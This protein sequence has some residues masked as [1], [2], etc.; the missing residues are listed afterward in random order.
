M[1]RQARLSI[2]IALATILV[3]GAPAARASDLWPGAF[4]S[5][6]QI[7]SEILAVEAAHPEIVDVFSIG[8]SYEGR[9]LYAAKIS[10]NV[11]LEEG[12]PEVLIDALHHSNEHVTLAQTLDLLHTLVDGY[13]ADVA[14]TALVDERVTWIVFA[15]NPDGL[16]FEFTENGP[17]NWRKN[18]QPT[19]GSSSI[20][21]DLNRNYGA[22][23]RCCN[24]STKNPASRI[25]AGPA[26]FSA[27][28]TAAMR[29]F[30]ASRV[31]NG[32]QRISIY[33]SLH[34][35]GRYVAWPIFPRSAGI[36]SMTIDDR[37]T[38]YALVAGVAARNGYQAIRYVPTGGTS[39]DWMYSTYKVPSILMEIGE[40][41]GE[42]TRFYPTASAM[43]SEVAGNRDAI[44]W[45]IGEASCP[46]EA[47]GLGS[48]RCG[49]R[50]DDFEREAGWV[51]NPDG[52]DTATSG[53]FERG[54]PALVRIGASIMQREN[55]ASGYRALVTGAAA[56]R[57]ANSNDL[58]GITTARSPEITLG[59][60]PGELAFGLAF[61]YGS[62]ATTAD[63][64][65]VWVEAA[66][67][68]RTLLYQ[69]LAA[70]RTR[71]ATYATVRR[72]LAAW[73]NQ[74]VRIVIGAGDV[75][76]DSLL[77]VAVDDV[78]VERR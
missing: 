28:E 57:T 45:L 56:G 4:K 24:T 52:T 33:L 73:A 66:D 20:G 11:A 62:S 43:A 2:T 39:T 18:R 76:R 22:Y 63:W 50:F 49:P 30:V 31:I 5:Y 9:E 7:E 48:R 77:E 65:R 19:P 51:V 38:M 60:D 72:S 42:V 21:T 47:A 41:T 71:W 59:A 68:T 37:L 15:V 17:W 34:A 10:D 13:G 26:R 54:R 58:D 27:P 35:A 46:S 74:T 12:E 44:L 78:R 29:D 32:V 61:S 36:P 53:R 69:K 23:W 67:G 8:Q 40:Y 16:A 55:G 75:G 1:T 6:E 64:F 70:S 14:I 25:Y 3:A